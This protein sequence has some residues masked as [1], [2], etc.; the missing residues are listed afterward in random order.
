MRQEV[1]KPAIFAKTLGHKLQV[2]AVLLG[3]IFHYDERIGN[4]WGVEQPASVAFAAFL[5]DGRN[6]NILWHT[7]FDETQKALSE[8]AFQ[9]FSF[10]RRGGKWITARQLASEGV[11]RVFVTF[12]GREPKRVN[13]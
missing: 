9:L 8:D 6:G 1:S 3:W 13:H 11:G 5:F 12:P 7:G 10:I 2:D 4:A